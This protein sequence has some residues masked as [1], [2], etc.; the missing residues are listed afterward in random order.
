ML[1]ILDAPKYLVAFKLADK[2]TAQDVDRSTKALADALDV[3]ERI[4]IFAEIDSSITLTLEGLWRDVVN[5]ISNFGLRKKIDRLA[6][7]SD[8]K[9][10]SALLRIEGMVFSS[11]EM[12]VFAPEDRDEAFAWASKEPES[13][14][15]P[16][17]QKRA[18][19][20]LQTTSD[21]VFAYEVDGRVT[22][23]D[24]RETVKEMKSHFDR[25][26]KVNVLARM[27][28]YKGFDLSALLIDDLYRMKY[29]ALSK[30]ERYAVVGAPT[31]MRNFLELIDPAFRVKI[32]VFESEQENAAWEWIGASQSLLAGGPS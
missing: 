4:N 28:G 30:V 14:P 29:H 24:I 19:R 11:I 20:F 2:L 23:D 18:I 21:K 13:L 31:W 27:S 15:K 10:Y 12:R 22:P 5:S 26:E 25:N 17:P 16:E 3:Q 6:V 1:E 9:V 7:V 8:S 32:R